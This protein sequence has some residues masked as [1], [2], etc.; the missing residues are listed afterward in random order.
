MKT[1][2]LNPGHAVDTPGKKSPDSSLLEYQ[3]NDEVAKITSDLLNENGIPNVIARSPREKTSLTFP[4]N[5][6]NAMCAGLGADNVL[7]VSIH[8]NAAGSGAWY[9]AQGWSIYTT[10]GKTESDNLATAIYNA[11]KE[12]FTD[13]KFRTDMSDGDPDKEAD[14]YVIRKTK[15]PSVLI[16]HFFMDNKDDCAYLKT[17]ECKKKAAQAIYKGLKKYMGV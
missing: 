16:E 4:V 3:W 1:I 14:F 12:V 13:R 9:N 8:V 15:C 17:T 11:A 2:V 7:F 6:A 10:K 5:V